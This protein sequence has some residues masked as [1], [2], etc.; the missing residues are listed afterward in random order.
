MQSDNKAIPYLS[1]YRG[2][3][4]KG[5]NFGKVGMSTGRLNVKTRKEK[6][7]NVKEKGK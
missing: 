1:T 6:K 7:K 2:G 3:A 4:D 5:V